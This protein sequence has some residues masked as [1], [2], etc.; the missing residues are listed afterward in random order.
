MLFFLVAMLCVATLYSVPTQY[1]KGMLR[2]ALG[3]GL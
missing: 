1:R 3:Q 2:E